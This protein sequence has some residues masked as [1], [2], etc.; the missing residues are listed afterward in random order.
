MKHCAILWDLDGTLLDTLE[1]LKDATNATLRHF[2]CP[3]RTLEEIRSFVGNGARNQIRM[4]LPGKAEDP[5]LDEVLAWYQEYY[6]RH[7][8]INTAPYAGI[9]EVLAELGDK[10]PMAIVSNKPDSAVKILCA[11]YFPGIYAQGVTD[12]CPRKP[13]PDMVWLAARELGVEPQQCIYVGDSEVD[14][15]TARNAGLRCISVL[16][17]FRD[18]DV[19]E[20]EGMD[21]MCDRVEDLPRVIAEVEAEIHGK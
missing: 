5:D 14:I 1:D 3:E 15:R 21:A 12:G 11:D 6:P 17:G 13:N 7:C 20:S 8:R 19:L 4:S 16:W 18:T 9:M 10:Y 2:G